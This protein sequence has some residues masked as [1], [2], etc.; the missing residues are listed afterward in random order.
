MRR[1]LAKLGNT[2]YSCRNIIISSSV[3]QPFVQSSVLAELRR[4]A[5]EA[6][7]STGTMPSPSAIH[8]ATPLKETYPTPY[9]YNAANREAREFYNN[10]GITATAF[11]NADNE[12]SRHNGSPVI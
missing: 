11:E 9:L 10:I 8:D 2:I 7:P 4:K 1:Q 12:T 5:T 3:E 6:A